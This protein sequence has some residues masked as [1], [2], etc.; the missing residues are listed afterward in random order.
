MDV[1]ARA[2]GAGIKVDV[3]ARGVARVGSRPAFRQSD[4]PRRLLIELMF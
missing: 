4:R 2:E 1:A 3:M